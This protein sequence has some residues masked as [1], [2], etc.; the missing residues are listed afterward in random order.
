MNRAG[1]ILSLVNKYQ[2]QAFFW[3]LR[4]CMRVWFSKWRHK[5][6]LPFMRSG[7][8]RLLFRGNSVSGAPNYLQVI[9]QRVFVASLRNPKILLPLFI[10]SLRVCVTYRCNLSYKACY[11]RGL[12]EEVGKTDMSVEDFTSLAGYCMERDWIRLRFLG[13]EPTVHPRFV[14]I[15]DA[16]YR[17]G[18][19]ISIP[20]NNLYSDEVAEKLDSRFVRDIAINYSA[21]LNGTAE[22]K[23]RFRKNLDHLRERGIPFSFS[24]ILDA[25]GKDDSLESLYKDLEEYLPLYIRVSLELPAFSDRQ[26]AFVPS[27]AGKFLFSRVYGMLERCAKIYVPFYIYRPIPLCLF[28]DEQGRRIAHY[29]NFIFF[30][31]CPLSYANHNGYG[32]LVTVNPDLST[33]PCASVFVKGPNILSFKDRRAV[34]DYYAEK[35]RPILET[36][37]SDAC[38]NCPHHEKFL[39]AVRRKEGPPQ[40]IFNDRMICQGGC[41]SLRRHDSSLNTCRHE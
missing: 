33:F 16:C 13:G 23:K 15:L 32:M 18:I 38:G 37:L 17:R 34:N 7:F 40:P 29:S 12:L 21:F 1:R 8:F 22:Q 11:A 4:K 19:E 30:T 28:S 9:F 6:I 2:D 26:F 39:G 27:E 20:T 41:F 3:L 5:A 24:Y 31:R 25:A 14:E 10:R 35:L 36:P